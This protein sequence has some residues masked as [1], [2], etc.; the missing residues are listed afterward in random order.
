M[1]LVAC[2][3][4]QAFLSFYIAYMLLILSRIVIRYGLYEIATLTLAMTLHLAR[5]TAEIR[6][7]QG[8]L[9]AR[10]SILVNFGLSEVKMRRVRLI[11]AKHAVLLDARVLNRT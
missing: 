3:H 10:T 11:F 9:K 1:R 4:G 6:A 2:R 7:R 8:A 5:K